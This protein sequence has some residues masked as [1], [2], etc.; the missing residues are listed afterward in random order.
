[1]DRNK[2]NDF[3]RIAQSGDLYDSADPELLAYQAEL[4]DRVNEFNLT[5]D[6][7]EGYERRTEILK[8][9]CGTY[10]ERL[11]ILPPVFAN[12]GLKH[13]HF[14]KDVFINFG[15]IFV[16]DADVFI[17]DN[18]MFGPRVTVVT[19]NHPISPRLR[20]PKIQYN[21]QVYI[22][23][24]VWVGA[25]AVI[26]SGVTIGDNAVIGAGSVVTRDVE[27]NTV[28]AGNPAREIRKITHL[29]DEIYDHIRKIDEEL[30]SKYLK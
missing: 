5:R 14:G 16:D 21:K 1:M 8:E 22:G 26:L 15:A 19:A 29:D 30:I 6:T 17:G 25:G 13:V 24:N 3:E 11:W 28:V 2:I 4:V 20:I 18:T 23:K 12:F 10:G 7:K 9:I 27:A